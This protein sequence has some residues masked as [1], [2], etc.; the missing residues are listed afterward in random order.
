MTAKKSF[1]IILRVLFVLFSLQFV[2]DAFYRWDGY[3]YYMRFMDFLPDLSLAFILWIIIGVILASTLWGIAYGLFRITSKFLITIRLEHIIAFFIFTGLS[4]CIKDGLQL[5]LPSK[6]IFFIYNIPFGNFISLISLAILIIVGVSV[7]VDIC[8]R[9]KYLEKMLYGLDARITPLVGL[10]ALLFILAVPFSLFKSGNPDKKSFPDRSASLTPH[11]EKRPNIIL[12]TMDALTARDMEAY[13][14][15]V[16]T[17]PFISKWAKDAIVFNRAYSSSNW[18]PPTTMSVMTGQRPWTHRVWHPTY[19]Y[20]V[21]NYENNLPRLLRNN[22]YTVY[23]L[24]QNP[25]AHPKALGIEDAFLIKDEWHT[26]WILS[27]WWL[28]KLQVFF[29]VNRPIIADWIFDIHR[30]ISTQIK[31]IYPP[32]FPMYTNSF[33]AEMVY[34]RFL[35]YISQ[36]QLSDKLQR[37]FFAWL[38]VLPPHYPYHPPETYMG[39]FGDA[40]IFNTL[41]KQAGAP[42]G[43]YAPEK[44][45]DVYL[46]R[47]RYDE[48]ILYSDQQL[49]LFLLQLAKTIDMSN[50]ILILSSDHGES[51]SHGYTSHDGPHLYE[52]FVHIPLIIKM[53]RSVKGK[54]IDSLVEQI[55]IAPTILNL[56]G[57]PVPQWMEGRALTPLFEDKSLEQRPVYSMQLIKNRSLGHDPITKGTIAVWDGDYKLIYYI[58]P[59][60][61]LLFNLR[62]DPDEI[63]NIYE[64]QPETAKRLLNLINS[65]LSEANKRIIHSSPKQSFP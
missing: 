6:R 25:A 52:P 51:F 29:F 24:I 57:I 3:S 49:K 42:Q 64:E 8:L 31:L 41:K 44:Q 50:T 48:F 56:A 65:Q 7:V 32:V 28:A 54:V 36:A 2:G 30:H 27:E 12:V 39:V 34:K 17:T 61:V 59:Q 46:L 10:F 55:D 19:L 16:P 38:H 33:P 22:G 20:P 13:G 63:R 26:F 45:K 40:E 60:E 1:L 14:Y 58:E 35:D 4:L 15:G 47:K 43:V 53:P 11:A 21:S 9:R 23:G 18:T 62:T 5:F 37:P